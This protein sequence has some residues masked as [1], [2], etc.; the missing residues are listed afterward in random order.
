MT[1][2]LSIALA[3]AL[4]AVPA[5][6]AFPTT[7]VLDDFNRADEN[8]LS[9]AGSWGASILS[10][11]HGTFK[12]V[13]NAIQDDSAADGSSS[14]QAYRD[15]Q[16][17]GPGVEAYVTILNPWANNASDFWF[18]VHG[19]SEGSSAVDGYMAVA[20]YTS[21]TWYYTVQRLDNEVATE[22][23]PSAEAGP[24][25]ANGDKLGIEATAA[26]VF[27]WY[28]KPA[29]GAWGQASGVSTRSDSTYTSGH[30]GV[31]KGFHDTTS[32]LDDFGGGNIVA[33]TLKRFLLLG[34]GQ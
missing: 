27:T 22:L 28:Y 19:R 34:V 32:T 12:L 17:Y 2:I 15:D 23:T 24:T 21:G 20:Y 29:A 26:G 3:Y 11:T 8:P 14:G 10:G 4:L 33:S 1:R 18:F 9:T 25:L 5:F 6:A 31:S 13:S 16:N 7:P 30:I